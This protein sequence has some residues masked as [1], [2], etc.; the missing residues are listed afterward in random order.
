MLPRGRR[1]N[2]RFS[3]ASCLNKNLFDDTISSALDWASDVTRTSLHD[4]EDVASALESVS[5][6]MMSHSEMPVDSSKSSNLH[7]ISD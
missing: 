6:E 2:G 5:L 1:G 4:Y 7:F 3:C